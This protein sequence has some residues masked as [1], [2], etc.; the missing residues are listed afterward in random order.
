MNYK[1]IPEIKSVAIREG[2]VSLK[3]FY[4][5]K[6]LVELV[7][8][9]TQ[10]LDEA[11]VG[12]GQKPVVGS[13]KTMPEEAYGISI[14]CDKI[15]IK[16]SNAKGIF[17]GVITLA[18]LSKL[19]DGMLGCCDIYDE[20]SMSIR[21][22]SDDISR[23]Q[24]ST[25]ENFKAIVRKMAQ[26]KYNVYMP[27]IEDVFAFSCEPESGKYSDAV[28]PEEWKE[29]VSYAD[30]YFIS[31]RPIVNMLGHWNKNSKLEAF[32]NVMLKIPGKPNDGIT[33]V[34]D[35]VNPK[36]RLMLSKMLD[37]VVE[38]FGKGPIHVGGDEPCE[39]TEA[40]GKAEGGR[41]FVEH[42]RWLSEELKKRGCTMLMYADMFA[43]PWGDYSVCIEKALE[44]PE[45]TTFVFWD[46]GVRDSYP[47]VE[48]LNDLKLNILVSPGT[49]SW[50]TLSPQLKVCWQNTKGLLKSADGKSKGIVMSSWNDGGDGLREANWPAIA[51]GALFGWSNNSNMTFEEFMLSFYKS[52][53]GLPEVKLD[54]LLPKYQFDEGMNTDSYCELKKEFWKDAR[55]PPATKL[56]QLAPELLEKLT[57]TKQ[58][59]DSL[60]P[61]CNLD[62]FEALS[63]C[64]ERQIYVLKK[65]IVLKAE[66]YKSREEALSQIDSLKKLSC[67]TKELREKHKEFW[68]KSNR[69]SEWGYVEDMY[70]DLEESYNS[71]I[72][73]CRHSKRLLE[74]KYLLE[75]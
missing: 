75:E 15:E 18:E 23:G 30:K 48:K 24:I 35:P 60:K 73:Y 55:K 41:L 61:V 34:L 9:A 4:A 29:I 40:Y 65:L 74:N 53:F 69:K 3:D 12:D 19:N 33:S 37:E 59:I 38:T 11:G 57:E 8:A 26:Y 6:E 62:A 45:G 31:V 28:K 63:F 7:P 32:N 72:R 64:L 1:I 52:F 47:Y 22:A 66:A 51:I 13:I 25:L 42:Y 54:K 44:L 39:L 68:H 70:M 17:Y 14:D 56:K 58:Y 10:I 67:C 46:Y 49:W 21:A 50:N 43:P 20:P 16:A 27:Y 36:V 2:S 5:E 71:L